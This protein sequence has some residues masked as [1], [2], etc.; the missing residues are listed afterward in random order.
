MR[1]VLNIIILCGASTTAIAGPCQLESQGRN[2]T[3]NLAYFSGAADSQ[4]IAEYAITRL[5][6]VS[7][8]DRSRLELVSTPE[9][10]AKRAR[11][12][13]CYSAPATTATLA[14]SPC[15]TEMQKTECSSHVGTPC[16]AAKAVCRELMRGFQLTATVRATK[17]GYTIF[18][19]QTSQHV[20]S[21]NGTLS[22]KWLTTRLPSRHYESTNL[23]M[24]F[25]GAML[26]EGILIPGVE[27]SRVEVNHLLNDVNGYRTLSAASTPESKEKFKRF[28]DTI[29]VYEQESSNAGKNSAT[30][31][32]IY[33]TAE[34]LSDFVTQLRDLRDSIWALTRPDQPAPPATPPPAAQSPATALTRP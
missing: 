30:T 3:L 31:T 21:T 24:N 34:Q 12:S 22:S 17:G 9:P 4:A 7:G 8:L 19:S 23:F 18:L 1:Q 20:T 29:K 25:W 28:D 33:S 16:E 27:L 14:E 5:L 10:W 15:L 2:E 32:Q 11:V 26:L 6:L 13:V